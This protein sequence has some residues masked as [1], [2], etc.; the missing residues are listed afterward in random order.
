MVI[1][2]AQYANGHEMMMIL[3]YL[4]AILSTFRRPLSKKYNERKKRARQSELNPLANN[5]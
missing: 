5:I 3:I 4:R 2:K 1:Y